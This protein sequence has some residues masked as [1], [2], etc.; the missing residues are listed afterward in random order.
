[1][2]MIARIS[3]ALGRAACIGALML[4]PG[5]TCAAGGGVADLAT[6]VSGSAGQQAVAGALQQTLNACQT[7]TINGAI[8]AAASSLNKVGSTSG[9]LIFDGLPVQQLSTQADIQVN[10]TAISSPK[11]H[12]Q[13]ISDRLEDLRAGTAGTI[14]ARL[15]SNGRGGGAGEEPYPLAPPF[16]VFVTASGNR[17]DTDTNDGETGLRARDENLTL[18]ADY[19][20]SDKVIGGLSFGYQRSKSEMDLSSGKLESDSYRF[21]PFVSIAPSEKTYIDAMLGYS[22][23]DFDSTHDCSTCPFSQTATASFGANQYFASLGGGYNYDYQAWNVRGYGRVD[24]INLHVDSYSETGSGPMNLHVDSQ[25]A[26]SLTSVIGAELGK[27]ISTAS[28]ILIPR[29][30]LEWVHEFKDD[31]RTINSQFQGAP[32]FNIGL[33]TTSPERNWANVG[34]G[35]QMNFVQAVAAFVDYEALVKND[36]SNNILSAGLRYEF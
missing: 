35:V 16:G 10:V 3:W 31:S 32:I 13:K 11:S 26:T 17:G 7:G 30:R 15:P 27:T 34:I 24:Y 1:M 12:I 20:F 19:R 5:M 8:C 36:T 18:G 9:N 21:G 33:K 4:L 14:Y 25:T 28:G 6:Q 2:K 23:I 29:L 22:R